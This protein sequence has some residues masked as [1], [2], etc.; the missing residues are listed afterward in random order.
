MRNNYFK[1]S[2]LRIVKGLPRE[3]EIEEYYFE[4]IMFKKLK[5]VDKQKAIEYRKLIKDERLN[6]SVMKQI[7]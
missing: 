3:I 2:N 4:K 1:K 7:Y 5:S 6:K